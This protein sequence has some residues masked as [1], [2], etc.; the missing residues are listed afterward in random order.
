MATLVA[1]RCVILLTPPPWFYR[2]YSYDEF[3]WVDYYIVELSDIL[4]LF[5]SVSWIAGYILGLLAMSL[6]KRRD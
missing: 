4:P 2:Y 3:A 6:W 5:G 1:W